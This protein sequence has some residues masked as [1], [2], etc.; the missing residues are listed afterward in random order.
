MQVWSS[1]RYFLPASK[2]LQSCFFF[3]DVKKILT[4]CFFF[5]WRKK[6]TQI[7]T[8]IPPGRWVHR[9]LGKQN[10]PPFGWL[11]GIYF[12]PNEWVREWWSCFRKKNAPFEET[13][14]YEENLAH[15]RPWNIRENYRT[16]FSDFS[17]GGGGGY[18]APFPI[19]SQISHFFF[20]ILAINDR[21]M[22]RPKQNKKNWFFTIIPI[23][24]WGMTWDSY[25]FRNSKHFNRSSVKIDFVLSFLF[26]LSI[27]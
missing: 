24:C 12:L 4:L 19:Q 6:K 1:A 26:F 7:F 27:S 10:T 25:C 22:V 14:N 3:W 9:F 20:L 2:F 23:K 15:F 8:K 5:H 17:W 11:G 18:P 21:Y 16:R 13:I